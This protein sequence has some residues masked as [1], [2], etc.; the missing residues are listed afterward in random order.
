MVPESGWRNIYHLIAVS[1]KKINDQIFNISA[2]DSRFIDSDMK[3]GGFNW[4]K[5]FSGPCS[6]S[7]K[8]TPPKLEIG[9]SSLWQSVWKFSSSEK[10]FISDMTGMCEEK[11]YE[12][13]DDEG[14]GYS[15]LLANCPAICS[16][17]FVMSCHFC[18]GQ[19]VLA[20]WMVTF[21]PF[22]YIWMG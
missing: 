20:I 6:S 16:V 12:H 4:G 14:K 2:I 1:H 7:E 21:C 17:I 22:I 5:I 11:R 3:I 8:S 18:M 19:N 13:N 9:L 10:S 15:V